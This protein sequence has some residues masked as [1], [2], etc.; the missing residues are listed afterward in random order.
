MNGSERIEKVQ[1]DALK[2]NHSYWPNLSASVAIR[3]VRRP[4][5][6]VATARAE[7]DERKTA[8]QSVARALF[9]TR[10]EWK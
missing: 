4:A 3:L 2:R 5:S 6:S 7:S 1:R 10:T 8:R 9:A